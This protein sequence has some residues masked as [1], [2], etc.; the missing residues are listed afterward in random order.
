MAPLPGWNS[1][2][3]CAHGLGRDRVD[4]KGMLAENRVQAGCEVGARDQFEDVVGAVA[5]RHLVDTD[6]ISFGQLLLEYETIAVGIARQLVELRP[7]RLDGFRAGTQG[8]LIARQFDDRCRIEV[9]LT[10]QFVYRLA[11]HV[12]R[13]F[14]HSWLSQGEEIT[15]HKKA[16]GC[17]LQAAGTS[18]S[19]VACN[20]QPGSRS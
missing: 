20:L 19:P 6:A 13:Q 11:R 4:R 17:R 16:S 9:E 8:V 18:R 10:R 14:L 7:D 1:L 2:G 3:L 15:T 5:E 12:G